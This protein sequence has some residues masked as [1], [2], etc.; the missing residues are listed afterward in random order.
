MK[1]LTKSSPRIV[2]FGANGQLG[3]ALVNAT[4]SLGPVFALTRESFD[5]TDT[6]K[7]KSFLS[8]IK[9]DL[10]INAAAFT[11][12]EQAELEPDL[13]Y[14][15]NT[16]FPK[17]LAEIIETFDSHLV[18][19]STDYVFDGLTKEPYKEEAPLKPLNV[20]GETKALGEKAILKATEKAFILRTSWLYGNRGNNFLT[21]LENLLKAPLIGNQSLKIVS[22][23]IGSPTTVKALVAATMELLQHP[24]AINHPGLYH[25]TCQGQASWFEF[26]LFLKEQLF[27]PCEIQGIKTS[28][29]QVKAKR[30]LYSVLDNSKLKR[31]FN[32]ELPFWEDAFLNLEL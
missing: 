28:T 4:T 15:I 2:V 29:F 31:T 30:P 6:R 17:V 13:A 3:R 16:R 25:M 24:E 23:Q 18:H 5:V 14:E 7:V 22:D 12:V 27:W 26:A 1:I 20:Y 9:P 21:K 8:R 19:Y 11:S 32:I 10:I